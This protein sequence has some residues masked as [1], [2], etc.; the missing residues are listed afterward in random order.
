MRA[1]GPRLG[2]RAFRQVQRWW[3]VGVAAA[4][5]AGLLIYLGA[6]AFSSSST[7]TAGAS[8]AHPVPVAQPAPVAH[9]APV[10]AAAPTGRH[11][12]ARAPAPRPARKFR[13]A[14][15]ARA[16]LGPGAGAAFERLLATLPGRVQV[17]LL[18]LDG[19]SETLLGG[20][21]PAQGWS[22]TKVAV[23]VSLLRARGGQGLTGTE[24]DEA[25]LAITE[26][27]NQAILDLFA[28]LESTE[29]GL[30]GASRYVQGVLGASGDDQTVVAT[31]PPPPGAV[32][33]FGQT[34]WAPGQAVKFF[35]ALALGRLLPSAETEYVLG[36]MESIVPSE[37]WGLGS[38]G[39]SVPVAFKGGWGPE[40]SGSYLVRQSGIIDPGSPRGIA[41]S[42]VAYPPG[43]ADSFAVG[44]E[45]LT[46]T[47]RWLRA[48]LAPWLR[49]ST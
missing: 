48:E 42:V 6:G 45:M 25:D 38:G 21:E 16:V 2:A 33:T 19:S 17:A 46:D 28:D 4:G 30:I 15:P 18:P 13:A 40:P 8:F 27:D 5:I 39:F 31:A 23:L 9:P 24:R 26:S 37:S 1:P 3:L 49:G 10:A 35:R 36:L 47:A 29:G 34:E 11:P 12:A 14:T 41:V 44:T 32:T 22:T 20:D 43:G 7:A